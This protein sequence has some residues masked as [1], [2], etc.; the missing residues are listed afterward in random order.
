[1]GALDTIDLCFLECTHGGWAGPITMGNP[2]AFTTTIYPFGH[3]AIFEAIFGLALDY[4]GTD[5][6]RRDVIASRW[7]ELGSV[8]FNLVR[9]RERLVASARR[10]AWMPGGVIRRLRRRGLDA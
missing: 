10:V 5:R 3:R 9:R 1:L 6:L 2:D 8:P 7:P 4:R